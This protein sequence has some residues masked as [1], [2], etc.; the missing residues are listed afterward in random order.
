[1]KSL[2]QNTALKQQILNRITEQGILPLF[3]HADPERSLKIVEILFRAGCQT[4]EYTNRGPDAFE[5]F[6]YL[7]KQIQTLCP[8]LS[9]GIGTVKTAGEARAFIS[10]GAD[11][12]ICPVVNSDVANECGDANVLWIPGCLTPTEVFEA[13]KHQASFVKIFPAQVVG[14]GYIGAIRELF[15]QM[16]FMPTGG[17]EI[18]RENLNAWFTEGVSAVGMGSK[19]IS[20]EMLN[21]QDL[22]ILH[23]RAVEAL[24]LVAEV[25]NSPRWAQ[26]RA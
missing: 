17:V 15:P 16:Q 5:N 10:A 3:Y 7:H 12:V 9:L 22:N 25:R 20:K 11:F 1:V 23:D 6:S 8:G 24:K 14:A 21:G 4:I 2:L 13:E 19:L 26:V 18:S